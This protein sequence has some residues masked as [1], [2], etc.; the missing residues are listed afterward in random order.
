MRTSFAGFV[1]AGP[2]PPSSGSRRRDSAAQRTMTRHAYDRI[3]RRLPMPGVLEVSRRVPL[4][5]AIEDLLLIAEC[6]LP[7]DWE[8]QVKYLPL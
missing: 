5:R 1:D 8:G 2:R 3:R 4:A 6:S 7:G